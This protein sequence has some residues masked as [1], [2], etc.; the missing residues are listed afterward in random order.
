[1]AGSAIYKEQA[2]AIPRSEVMRRTQ[3]QTVMAIKRLSRRLRRLSEEDFEE[4]A[5]GGPL[6]PDAST[7]R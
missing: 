1:M 6:E 4:I 2:D 5:I 7:E 3:R